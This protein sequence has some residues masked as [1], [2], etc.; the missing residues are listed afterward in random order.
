MLVTT[1]RVKL[2]LAVRQWPSTNHPPGKADAIP[3]QVF[4]YDSALF[5]QSFLFLPITMDRSVFLHP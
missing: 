5:L 2:I 1:Q 3:G 4:D